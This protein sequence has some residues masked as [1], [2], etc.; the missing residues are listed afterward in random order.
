MALNFDGYEIS[1]IINPNLRCTEILLTTTQDPDV[2]KKTL[3]LFE[4]QIKY[5]EI[6]EHQKFKRVKIYIIDENEAMNLDFT[7]EKAE[8]FEL[9]LRS[10]YNR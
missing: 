7:Q 1:Q 2:Q 10:L 8:L 6:E 4:K 3:I 9:F 5:I